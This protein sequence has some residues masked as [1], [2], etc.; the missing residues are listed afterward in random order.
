MK[1]LEGIIIALITPIAFAIAFWIG[2][3]VRAVLVKDDYK[4]S[5]KSIIINIAIGMIALVIL[6]KATR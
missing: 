1:T 2:A 6:Q 3:V 5:F 4:V